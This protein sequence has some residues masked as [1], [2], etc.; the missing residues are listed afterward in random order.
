VAREVAGWMGDKPVVSCHLAPGRLAALREGDDLDPQALRG[1]DVLAVAALADP[2][3]FVEQ[4]RVWGARVEEALFG[5]HHAFSA[6]EAE[7][8][9][10]RAGGRVVVMTRKDAVKLRDLFPARAYVLEQTVRFDWGEEA[11]DAAL[12]RALERKAG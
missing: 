5:D 6:R 10:A 11:L 7:A 1:Q 2:G 8:L 3:P 12:L 9:A 4:L